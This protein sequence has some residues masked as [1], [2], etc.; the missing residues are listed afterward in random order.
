MIFEMWSKRAKWYSMYFRNMGA[1]IHFVTIGVVMA[2][3][4]EA[5]IG[6][7]ISQPRFVFGVSLPRS[8]ITLG[9]C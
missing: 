3:P 7:P 5:T 6:R 1:K 2:I 8:P 4:T 9:F